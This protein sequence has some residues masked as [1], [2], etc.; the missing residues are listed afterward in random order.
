MLKQIIEYIDCSL[1]G[2]DHKYGYA[3]RVQEV[4]EEGGETLPAVYIG[5]EDYKQVNFES[6]MCYHRLTGART[7]AYTEDSLSTTTR[8]ITL[9]YPML[10]VGCK[11]MTGK[12]RFEFEKISNG[13]ANDM[14]NLLYSRD[15]RRGIK[16]TSIELVVTNINSDRHEV[17]NGEFTNVE[18]PVNY[19]YTLFSI[20]YN[21]IINASTNCLNEC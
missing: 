9:T 19:N 15:L 13:V 4:K 7:I 11:K 16:V 21:I 1:N 6:D 17:W 14:M 8:A 18:M 20:G 2:F 12:D 10:F 5:N 3:E